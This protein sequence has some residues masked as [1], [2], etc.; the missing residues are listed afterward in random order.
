MSSAA[1]YANPLLWLR[2]LA[3]ILR[4]V[5][6]RLFGISFEQYHAALRQTIADGNCHSLLD[7]GCGERSPIYRFSKSIHR[8]TGVDSHLPSI[9]RSRAQGIHTDYVQ[10][11]IA[12]IGSRF[13]PRSFDCVVA[14][15]VIEHFEKDD[16]L[17]LLDA[18]ERIARQKAVIFTPNGFVAQPATEDNPHQLHKSGWTVAQMRARGYEVRGIGGWPPLRGAYAL[19]RIRPFWLTER[20]SLLTERFFESRPEQAFQLL[21][22]K[23]MDG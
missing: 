8:T 12:E 23:R 4:A 9:E 22:T 18:M 1:R 10:M 5:D 17:R 21:S 2:K 20:L 16:G 7:V 6:E 13:A 3:A 19:P 14:L 15:D 11:N